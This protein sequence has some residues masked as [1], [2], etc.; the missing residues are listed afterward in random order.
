MYEPQWHNFK[1]PAVHDPVT[2]DVLNVPCR[3]L[4]HLLEL[5]VCGR[6]WNVAE[7]HTSGHRR[8]AMALIAL[9]ALIAPMALAMGC[10]LLVRHADKQMDERGM[11]R[12]LLGP[13]VMKGA[14]RL[15]KWPCCKQWP[16]SADWLAQQTS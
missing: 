3:V 13:S 12:L 5:T 9:I 15:T 2:F 7:E 14:R 4:D 1:A 11:A 8:V 6:L 10:L 16:H